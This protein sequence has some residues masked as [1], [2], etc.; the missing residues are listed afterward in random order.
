MYTPSCA[1]LGVLTLFVQDKTNRRAQVQHQYVPCKLLVP[2]YKPSSI[3]KLPIS[4]GMDP[5]KLLPVSDSISSC[6]HWDKL[7]G[8]WPCI[9]LKD[10][11]IPLRCG[12]WRQRSTGRVPDKLLKVN[13]TFSMVEMLKMDKGMEPVS[14]L[15]SRFRNFK[16]WRFPI[17]SG[18]FPL[19]EFPLKSRCLSFDRLEIEEGIRPVK[20][21]SYKAKT[22]SSGKWPNHIG[23]APVKLLELKLMNLRRRKPDNSWGRLPWK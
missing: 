7:D 15:I 17:C 10:R 3:S 12:R 14:W 9:W 19:R 13:P 16:L 8:I 4:F 23:M 5:L 20:S 11:W 22:W 1:C 6:E 18:I 21:L 2:R